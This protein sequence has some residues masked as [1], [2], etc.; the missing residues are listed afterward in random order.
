MMF[1]CYYLC[2]NTSPGSVPAGWVSTFLS[3]SYVLNNPSD[4]ISPD[5]LHILD[6]SDRSGHPTRTEIENISAQVL[7]DLQD[8]QTT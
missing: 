2:V 8:S 1:R 7:Q 5:P 4:R 6:S 3:V